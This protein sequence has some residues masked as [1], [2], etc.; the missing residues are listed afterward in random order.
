MSFISDLRHPSARSKTIASGIFALLL[1]FLVTIAIVSGILVRQILWLPRAHSTMVVDLLLGHPSS[2]TFP[3]PGLK[4]I[5]GWFFPGLRGAP[6]IILCHGYS[7]HRD[8]IL[9]LEA[10]LQEHHYNVFVFDFTGH[11]SNS[12]PTTLGYIESRELQS[13][14]TGLARRDDIDAKRFGVWGTDMGA[15]AAVSV[16]ENDPRIRALV[17]TSVYNDPPEM[18]VI[19]ASSSGLGVIPLVKPLCRLEFYLLNYDYRFV[20]P[21]STRIAR[22]RDD[23]KLFV[24]AR[25][26]PELTGST[27]KLFQLAPPPKFERS[28]RSAYVQMTD[29]DKRKYESD[30]VNFYLQYLPVNDLQ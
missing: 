10:A 1:F 8:D 22:L 12:G 15:Y 24:E 21:L 20:A 25:D 2:V 5:E 7:S 26:I 30:I 9:T 19:Q 6:T 14:V 4:E 18:L 17:V 23:A 28:D 11:G 3:S 29:E 16:A 27:A 13:V